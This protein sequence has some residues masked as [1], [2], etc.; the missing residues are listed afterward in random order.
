MEK[1]EQLIAEINTWLINHHGN[2]RHYGTKE[3]DAYYTISN[4]KTLIEKGC[5]VEIAKEIF[6]RFKYIYY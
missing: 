5:D 3:A 4:V 1:K 2:T 6:N